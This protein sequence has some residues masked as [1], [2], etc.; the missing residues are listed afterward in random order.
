MA[1][2]LTAFIV[3]GQGALEEEN[4]A[5]HSMA[6]VALHCAKH[7]KEEK[8]NLEED[9]VKAELVRRRRQRR[10]ALFRR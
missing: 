4:R 2:Q 3:D 6:S 7:E 1:E 9:L 8:E 5:L 10:M